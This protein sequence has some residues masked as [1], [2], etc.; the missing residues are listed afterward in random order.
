LT[1]KEKLSR[2]FAVYLILMQS[3]FVRDIVQRTPYRYYKRQNPDDKTEERVVIDRHY[4]R[5][6][7]TC[8]EQTLCFHEWLKME[9]FPK[10]EID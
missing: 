9:E 10:E 1:G 4:L 6:I 2:M 8:H 7:L 3:E 5:N